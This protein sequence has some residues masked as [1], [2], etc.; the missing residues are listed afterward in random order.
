MQQNPNEYTTEQ[1]E[2]FC[3]SKLNKVAEHIEKEYGI[4]IS[5]KPLDKDIGGYYRPKDHTIALKFSK[6]KN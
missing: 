4:S 5:F 1:T 2:I 6:L 3:T